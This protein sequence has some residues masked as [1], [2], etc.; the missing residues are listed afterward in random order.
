[1]GD[2]RLISIEAYQRDAESP[3][4]W[5]PSGIDPEDIVNLGA[6]NEL[7]PYLRAIP[8][9]HVMKMQVRLPHHHPQSTLLPGS[10]G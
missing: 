6:L 4:W 2:L 10:V 1:M 3:R 7:V 9:K 5:M 8:K